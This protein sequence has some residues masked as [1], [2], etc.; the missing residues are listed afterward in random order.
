M[1][2]QLFVRPYALARHSA[3]PLSEERRSF[4]CHLKEC[5]LPQVTL[6]WYAGMLLRVAE[7]LSLADRPEETISR[8]EIN[9]KATDKQHN[10]VSVA[11]R[12][13]RYLGRLQDE[14]IPASPYAEQIEAF[15]DFLRIERGL[16]GRT[17]VNRCVFLQKFLY[18]LHV[19]IDSGQQI[20]VA[21][22][23]RAFVEVISQGSFTPRSIQ[24][25]ASHLRAFF[26]YAARQGWCQK[27]LTES[28]HGP[29]TF[30]QQSLPAGPSWDDVQRLLSMTEGSRPVD[31][32]DRAILMFFAIYGLRRGEVARLKLS[33]FDWERELL[34]V[35]CSRTRR[36]RMYPLVYPVGNAVL[37]YLKE[38][39]PSSPHQEV[40]LTLLHPIRPL[41][42]SVAHAARRRL[43]RLGVNL[44]HYGPHALRHACATHLLSQGRT[45]KEIGDHLGHRDLNTTRIYAK[46]DL[47]GLRLVADFDLGGL[48]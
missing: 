11:T 21:D 42:T 27:E 19:P 20:T 40:F 1:F 46:V 30:T 15:A 44:P 17:I 14:L 48:E 32:R 29:R 10:F 26:H 16:S 41:R 23:D 38:V 13:L 35:E 39:R 37:R 47:G 36:T 18:H 31:I 45:L 33:D 7:T 5:G 34:F 2:E 6:I 9:R 22:V 3:S 8:N 25:L 4:L 12:W 28:I 24:N 43:R